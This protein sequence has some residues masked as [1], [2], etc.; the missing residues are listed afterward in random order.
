MLFIGLLWTLNVWVW[1]QFSNI[2]IYSMLMIL[3]ALFNMYIL[4]VGAFGKTIV[5]IG[6][7]KIASHKIQYPFPTKKV[8]E[9]KDIEEILCEPSKWSDGYC[10]KARLKSGKKVKL[11]E[12]ADRNNAQFILT[13]LDFSVRQFQL[14]EGSK[15]ASSLITKKV[16]Q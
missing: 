1:K 15:K 6:H 5:E 14:N 9:T 16:I 12:A 7:D 11:F 2:N 10:V 3:S 8:L 4:L 13:A